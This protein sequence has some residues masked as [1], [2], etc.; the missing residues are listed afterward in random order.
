SGAAPTPRAEEP[1][2]LPTLLPLRLDRRRLVPLLHHHSREFD[3]PFPR[4]RGKA[5]LYAPPPDPATRG[6][7][8]SGALHLRTR[9]AEG[10]FR[11]K[12]SFASSNTPGP[13]SGSRDELSQSVDRGDR[14]AR[15][16][17]VELRGWLDGKRSSGKL[18]FL[19]VRDGTGVIQCVMFKGDVPEA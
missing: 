4:G 19:Q 2:A 12:P 3:I 17:D 15:G 1:F 9:P 14:P 5:L 7:L 10:P 13:D 16:R 8:R 18:H 11:K 6:S